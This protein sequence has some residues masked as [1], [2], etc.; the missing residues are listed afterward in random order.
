MQFCSFFQVPVPTD[1]RHP[2]SPYMSD[3]VFAPELALQPTEAAEQ[4]VAPPFPRTFPHWGFA[5]FRA[6]LFLRKNCLGFNHWAG[7][8]VFV[9]WGV[10]VEQTDSSL[11]L[12]VIALY[13]SSSCCRTESLNSSDLCWGRT[14]NFPLR[15]SPVCLL[16]GKAA[17]TKPDL[18]TPARALRNVAIMIR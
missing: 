10:H 6:P 3:L 9:K 1:R 5:E 14:R 4:T 17:A 16:L 2:T 18:C 11:Y 12:S 7:S 15:N 8:K 13:S